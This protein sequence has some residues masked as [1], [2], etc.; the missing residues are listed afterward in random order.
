VATRRAHFARPTGVAT[1]IAARFGTYASLWQVIAHNPPR[2]RADWAAQP[3]GGKPAGKVI[4]A[5][6]LVDFLSRA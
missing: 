1:G 3:I 2:R 4:T 5:A 6:P